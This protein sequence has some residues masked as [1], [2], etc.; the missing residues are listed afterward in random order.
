MHYL[1]LL[2]SLYQARPVEIPF[3]MTG[4]HL[5]VTA[6]VNDSGPYH[7]IFDTGAGGTVIDT[8]R[9]KDLSLRS[10][11]SIPA[12]GA[13]EKTVNASVHQGVKVQ[14]NGMPVKET[15]AFGI[16]LEMVASFDGREVDGIL[17]YDL[18]GKSVVEFDYANSKILIHDPK[19]FKYDGPG[20]KLPFD[21]VMNHVRIKATV[22]QP[23]KDP[24]EGVFTIDTGGA[25]TV[26]INS[27][28]AKEHD[29]MLPEQKAMQPIKVGAGV[30]GPV[31]G[32]LSRI[33]ELR[34]GNVTI[35][36]P[37]TSFVTDK[38]GYFAG[39]GFAGTLGAGIL[40]RFKVI[41]NY[42]AKEIIFE[43]NASFS[44]PDNEGINGV[45]FQAMPPDF[46][47]I[48]VSEVWDG[49]PAAEAGVKTGDVLLELNGKPAENCTLEDIRTA[50][51]AA[52]K[53]VKLKLKRG[54]GT[55]NAEFVVKPIK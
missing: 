42:P 51:R 19:E 20:E 35:P 32:V 54:E 50:T 43:K 34:I 3:Q 36:H 31:H 46:H 7:F 27:P 24:V 45:A 55:V 18:F 10:S 53:T 25:N 11:G 44:E 17:G 49:L 5:Y 21:L 14:M 30:G 47:P 12:G 13:G 4:R 48:K 26:A 52:G 2:A 16:P 1:L 37:I 9:A 28:F 8:G 39:N 15:T 29:L 33:G 41:I 40:K 23:G 22:V 6:K 38:S